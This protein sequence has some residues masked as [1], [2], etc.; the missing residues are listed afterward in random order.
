MPAPRPTELHVLFAEAFNRG[1]IKGLLALYEPG[2]TVI[3]SGKPMV[4]Q[5]RVRAAIEKWLGAGGQM[6][7]DT[8]AVIEGPDGLV[9]LHGAWAVR[10]SERGASETI[11]QGLSTEVARRQLDG[12][13]R[14]IIDNPDTPI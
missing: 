3:V 4:G 14:L 5:E 6:T 1:D 13:W 10:T 8:R 11:R 7:L 2:A 12:T 9:V